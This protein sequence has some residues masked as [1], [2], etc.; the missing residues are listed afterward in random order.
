MP[1]GGNHPWLELFRQ[2]ADDAFV[3]APALMMGANFVRPSWLPAGPGVATPTPA[4]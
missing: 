3:G 2:Y 1:F 4:G